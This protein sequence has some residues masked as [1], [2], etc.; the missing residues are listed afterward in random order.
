MGFV[1]NIEGSLSRGL[2]LSLPRSRNDK[3]GTDRDG[4]SDTTILEA[5]LGRLAHVET[6]LQRLAPS[7]RRHDVRGN[8]YPTNSPM[9]DS[10]TVI[11]FSPVTP[12][13][14]SQFTHDRRGV[15]MLLKSIAAV[16][17]VVDPKASYECT[18][19]P[20]P[21]YRVTDSVSEDG[22][23]RARY[24]GR[25]PMAC[26]EHRPPMP[27][28]LP[29]TDQLRRGD[30]MPFVEYFLEHCD[31][32]FPIAC[33]RTTHSFSVSVESQGFQ[34]DIR[35]CFVLLL[36]ALA[37]AY[38]YNTVTDS[39]LSDFQLVNQFLVRIGAQISID[40]VQVQIF[41]ALFLLKKGWLIN[42]W[43][44]LLTRCTSLYNLI[45]R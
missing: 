4:C 21:I 41:R 32:L 28:L 1:V 36:M 8:G 7:G 33:A 3:I 25:T 18:F 40:Y 16:D 20:R 10:P 26:E 22:A 35:S 17:P 43:D 9:S 15:N 45:R 34:D 37:K 24:L 13:S 39:G 23:T 11:G 2:P 5:L 6:G 30:I 29:R 44:A 38:K 42:F 12:I 27:D 31:I 19:D 14:E